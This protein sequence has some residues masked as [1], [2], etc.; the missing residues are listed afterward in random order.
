VLALALQVAPP[1]FAGSFQ[2]SL[3]Q[4]GGSAQRVLAT[5]VTEYAEPASAASVLVELPASL[6]RGVQG[7]D[8][9]LQRGLK[10]RES[11][12]TSTKL[13]LLELD[14]QRLQLLKS[15]SPNLAELSATVSDAL[16]ATVSDATANLAAQTSEQA[17]QLQTEL[18]ANPYVKSTVETV[19]PLVPPAV[20]AARAAVK[21]VLRAGV[22]AL[23]FV[24]RTQRYLAPYVTS[25]VREVA[26]SLE[27]IFAD[28]TVV[29]ETEVAPAVAREASAA[30]RDAQVQAQAAAD[31]AAAALAE[32]AQTAKLEL[33]AAAASALD[34]AAGAL[35]ATA[36][37]VGS[38]AEVKAR[39][40]VGDEAVDTALT[41]AA[42]AWVASQPAL[43]TAAES[44]QRLGGAAATAAAAE[45]RVV[46]N[47]LVQP[48]FERAEAW[49]AEEAVLAQARGVDL[50]SQLRTDAAERAAKAAK[51]AEAA[52]ADA[53]L[54]EAALIEPFLSDESPLFAD[55]AVA[56]MDGLE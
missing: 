53:R 56:A 10:A 38:A 31:L 17:A 11:A 27:T 18:V 47:S 12:M 23:R 41:Q 6:E 3:A 1:S 55:E 2:G 49:L 35:G 28:A 39:E 26:A 54:R 5:E 52:W 33:D 44:A 50:A 51:A 40:A 45:A 15:G 42:A 48:A 46:F 43:R 8:A 4:A 13:K 21:V 37:Q 29:V 32:S 20:R 19:A 22:A 25:A 30:A 36:G 24:V 7:A 9:L 14:A 16:S 34:R